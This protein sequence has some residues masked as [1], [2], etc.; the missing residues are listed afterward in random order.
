MADGR[1]WLPQNLNVAVPDS[2]CFDDHPLIVK[3]MAAY[4]P[5]ML[6]KKVVRL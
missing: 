3:N 4:I 1:M 5:G 2:Y 6:Q